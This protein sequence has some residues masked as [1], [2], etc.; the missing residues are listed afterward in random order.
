MFTAM[1]TADSTVYYTQI[2]GATESMLRLTTNNIS[3]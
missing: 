3:N 1:F 2:S